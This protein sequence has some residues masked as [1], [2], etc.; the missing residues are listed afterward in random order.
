MQIPKLSS[1]L[2]STG[3]TDV[4]LD[5]CSHWP[6]TLQ[7]TN[8]IA[9]SIFTMTESTEMSV[10]AAVQPSVRLD[11]D[12]S[13][14]VFSFYPRR[15]LRPTTGACSAYLQRDHATESLIKPGNK[16]RA[17]SLL[18]TKLSRRLQCIFYRFKPP[19]THCRKKL[20]I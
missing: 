19:L 17:S 12:L 6:E 10:P 2:C 15:Q 7:S 20:A 11:P 9:I 8:R 13:S 18:H 3:A 1:H 16:C 4:P 14:H 5:D